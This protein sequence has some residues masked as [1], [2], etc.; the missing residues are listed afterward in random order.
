MHQEQ[1]LDDLAKDTILHK[2]KQSRVNARSQ[3]EMRSNRV[4]EKLSHQFLNWSPQYHCHH[5][6]S[7]N[8]N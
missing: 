1:L 4:E 3:M 2:Q 7:Q 5:W 6:L 8:K